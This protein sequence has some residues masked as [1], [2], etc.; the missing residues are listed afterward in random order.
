[1]DR[2]QIV[3]RQRQVKRDRQDDDCWLPVQVSVDSGE[4]VSEPVTE[5]LR[6]GKVPDVLT[7]TVSYIGTTFTGLPLLVKP[8]TTLWPCPR[9]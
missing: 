6:T 2:R 5:P 7:L 4:T 8:A 9:G 3:T 1:V